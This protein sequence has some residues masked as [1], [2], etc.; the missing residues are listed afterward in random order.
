M[1]LSRPISLPLLEHWQN[2][3]VK[4]SF[5]LIMHEKA[6]IS[7]KCPKL[8][9]CNYL[10]L[11]LDVMDSFCITA[12]YFT[13]YSSYRSHCNTGH[14]KP[15]CGKRSCTQI[16]SF[17]L[18]CCTVTGIWDMFQRSQFLCWVLKQSSFEMNCKL[19]NPS[20]T[21]FLLIYSSITGSFVQHVCS[22]E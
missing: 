12:I 4:R 13:F 7:L 20:V 21:A 8:H 11:S 10:Y 2:C 6:R 18:Y 17:V 16:L 5:T 9:K 1:A 3:H 19:I 14:S 22:W 15:E